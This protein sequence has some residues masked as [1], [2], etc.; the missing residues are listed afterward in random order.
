MLTA[1]WANDRNLLRG[2]FCLMRGLGSNSRFWRWSGLSSNGWIY[3][4]E[5][6]CLT[7]TGAEL[8]SLAILVLT[9]G[10]NLDVHNYFPSVNK[11]STLWRGYCLDLWTLRD[12]YI[13]IS[14]RSGDNLSAG[15]G[16][17]DK[18]V[19]EPPFLERKRS[20]H[21]IGI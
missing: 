10:T 12:C 1:I 21:R 16:L 11:A 15:S 5:R 2:R 18:L 19:M 17:H 6:Q 4:G 9:V 13:T 8:S 3:R 20:D 7:A 14:R